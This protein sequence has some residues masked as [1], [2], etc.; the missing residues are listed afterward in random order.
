MRS[1]QF[2]L[3]YLTSALHEHRVTSSFAFRIPSDDINS[4]LIS[5]VNFLCFE[6]EHWPLHRRTV[7][8]GSNNCACSHK[9]S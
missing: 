6:H 4:Y 9:S 7:G 1:M 8:T 5:V 3:A 2:V